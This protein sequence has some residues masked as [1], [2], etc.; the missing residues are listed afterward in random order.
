M[1]VRYG[2]TEW[3]DTLNR[4]IREKQRDIDRIL[5]EYGVPLLDA[6][7]RLINPPPWLQPAAAR[8]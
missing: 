2:E 1:G 7:G 6:A 3:L 4:L 5:N 8:N